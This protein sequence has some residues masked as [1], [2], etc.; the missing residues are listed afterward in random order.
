M[1]RG[2]MVLDTGSIDTALLMFLIKHTH[3]DTHFIKQSTAVLKAQQ[4]SVTQE[5]LYFS[6]ELENV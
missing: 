1:V 6:H 4:A 3:T 2:L 5:S